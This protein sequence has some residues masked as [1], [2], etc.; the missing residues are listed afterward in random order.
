MGTK[1]IVVVLIAVLLFVALLLTIPR[2][3]PQDITVRH[4]GSVQSGNV[5]TM[6]FEI[7]NHTATPYVFL[8]FEVQVRN[9]NAWTKFQ[10]FGIDTTNPTPPVGPMGLASYTINVTNLPAKSVVRFSIRP[11]KTL[12]G[13][14]GFV[15]RA[16]LKLKNQGGGISLSPFDRNSKV[17]EC[18]LRLRARNSWNLNKS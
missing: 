10:G 17:S 12:L 7:K 8:P 13:F 15:R 18:P 14:N 16:E 6:T 2:K 4:V 1:A 3:P 9:G 11:Q 5:T